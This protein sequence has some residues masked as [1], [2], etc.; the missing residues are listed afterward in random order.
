MVF[1]KNKTAPK[2]S[3]WTDELRAIVN[4]NITLAAELKKRSPEDPEIALILS[5]F[6]MIPLRVPSSTTNFV[7]L[8]RK[9][10]GKSLYPLK[11]LARYTDDD[12]RFG[13]PLDDDDFVPLDAL[14][15]A[16]LETVRSLKL[17]N[18]ELGSN[19]FKAE[20][21]ELYD[22]M[23]NALSGPESPFGKYL[24]SADNWIAQH[25]VLGIITEARD[26]PVRSR[27]TGR[28]ATVSSEEE[29]SSEEEARSVGRE[30]QDGTEG[31]EV[32]D[33]VGDLSHA[34]LNEVSPSSLR[35]WCE[36]R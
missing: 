20:R 1:T 30:S 10:S 32:V 25:V 18:A 3:L 12:A 5:R 31:A 11:E 17:T 21:R 33:L 15:S 23:V 26:A 24:V 4:C 22:E 16:Q 9:Q 29:D 36:T 13:F 8:S 7:R 6:P 19:R 35:F 27:K 14:R 34:S 2:P 28:R